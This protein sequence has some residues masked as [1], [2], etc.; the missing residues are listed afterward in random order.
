MNRLLRFKS[1]NIQSTNK[2]NIRNFFNNATKD[3]INSMRLEFKQ[4]MATMRNEFKQDMAVMRNEFKQDMAAM[5][6]EFKQDMAAMRN[7]FKEAIILI[8]KDNKITHDKVINIENKIKIIIGTCGTIY[9]ITQ[10]YDNI[11][12]FIDKQRHRS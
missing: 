12:E 9:F 8:Q 3:D 11:T 1:L 7:D 6:N 10:F 4:D 5:R 2:I